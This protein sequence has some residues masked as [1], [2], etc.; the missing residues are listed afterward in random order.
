MAKKIK[1][2]DAKALAT[3]CAKQAAEKLAADI[4]LM[5]ISAI[6]GSPTEWFVI[7][8]CAS[9][10]QLRAVSETLEAATKSVGINHPR[11]EGKD[12]Q[13]WVILDYFDV[14]VHLMK[15]EAR[16][17][18]KLEKLWGDADMF[19]LSAAGRVVKYKAD[20]KQSNLLDEA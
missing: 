3:F 20:K 13:N 6:D 10:P 11:T 7:A 12:S 5:D 15:P 18:Y 14:V 9:D 8:T 1:L 17:F 19:T 2:A 4:V 16:S